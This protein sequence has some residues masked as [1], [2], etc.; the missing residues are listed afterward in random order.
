M[1]VLMGKRMGIAGREHQVGRINQ[2]NRASEVIQRDTS[3]VRL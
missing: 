3:D 1:D 2:R